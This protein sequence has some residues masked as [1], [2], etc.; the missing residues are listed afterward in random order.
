MSSGIT[1]RHLLLK[2]D[3]LLK[4][5]ALLPGSGKQKRMENKFDG[6]ISLVYMVHKIMHSNARF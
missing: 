3:L 2:K 4:E 5:R 1:P 6:A